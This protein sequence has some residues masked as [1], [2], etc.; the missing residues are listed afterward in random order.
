MHLHINRHSSGVDKGLSPYQWVITWVTEGL[1]ETERSGEVS[2]ASAGAGKRETA[3]DCMQLVSNKWVLNFISPLTN[4][5][6]S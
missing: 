2:L 1:S 6:S 3:M 4:F 5:G